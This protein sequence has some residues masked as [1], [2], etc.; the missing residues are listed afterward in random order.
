MAT[1]G[2]FF[3]CLTQALG[4]LIIHYWGFTHLCEQFHAFALR[5]AFRVYSTNCVKNLNLTQHEK[6]K[7]R[8]CK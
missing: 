4:R 6:T 5:L 2:G 1:G 3:M 8:E 7:T